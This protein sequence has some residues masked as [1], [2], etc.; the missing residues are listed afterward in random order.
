[1]PVGIDGGGVEFYDFEHV[2]NQ[3]DFKNRYRDQ[4]DELDVEPALADEMV[5]EANRAFDF[6]GAIFAHLDEVAG[7]PV[8]SKT[9]EAKPV[10]P[11][12][13][14]TLKADASLAQ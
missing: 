1:M 3:K 9:G 8:P 5:E 2:D 7:I 10:L 12:G 14:P 6:N 13:H 11:A 4:L